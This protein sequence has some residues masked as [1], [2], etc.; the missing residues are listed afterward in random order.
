MFFVIAE[1]YLMLCYVPVQFGFVTHCTMN[2]TK[3]VNNMAQLSLITLHVIYKLSSLCICFLVL[4]I[5]QDLILG[6]TL[7]ECPHSDWIWILFDSKRF[8][9][10][11]HYYHAIGSMQKTSYQH[12]DVICFKEPWDTDCN[13]ITKPQSFFTPPYVLW[14]SVLGIFQCW[15]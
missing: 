11:I 6:F 8:S 13:S 1:F 5:L 12:Y 2:Q 14:I 10:A 4:W 9:V 7:I 3:L 15:L